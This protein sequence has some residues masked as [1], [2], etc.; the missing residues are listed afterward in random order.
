MAVV[1]EFLA[2]GFEDIEALAPVDILRRGG[3]EVKT[4]SITGSECVESAHGV[5]VKAD[6]VF[7]QAGDFSDAAMLLLPGGMPGAANLRAHDGV[8]KA[9]LRQHEG[10]RMIGAICAAPMVLGALGILKGKRATCYP[11]FEKF[12]EG[13]EYTAE[14][15][16]EDGQI[17][18]GEGPAASFPYG[19]TLLA[20]FRETEAV[21]SIEDGMR[22]THLMETK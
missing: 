19:Y 12:L 22:Y 2:N 15:V 20:R 5:T 7:E 10:G 4:V 13:A 3:V 18:T 21:K 9:L 8:C 14:L 16:T 1:Y 17:I 11:G 6:L